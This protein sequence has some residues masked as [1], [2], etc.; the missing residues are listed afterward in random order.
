M[1]R[2]EKPKWRNGH[3]EPSFRRLWQV[4]VFFLSLIVMA[5]V[6][7]GR[8]LWRKTEAE[9]FR[10]RLREVQ[11]ALEARPPDLEEVLSLGNA[12][13]AESEQFPSLA[14]QLHFCLGSAYLLSAQDQEGIRRQASLKQARFHL[15]RADILGVPPRWKPKLDYRLGKVWYHFGHDPKQVIE[16]LRNTIETAA[17][18]QAEGYA[19]LTQ[20]Y[21]RLPVPD[22]ANALA[23]TKKHL[24]LPTA[25]DALL[26]PVRLLRGKLLFQLD[27]VDEARQVLGRIGDEAA[28]EIRAEARYWQ[29]KCAQR[30]LK[31]A[32]AAKLWEAVLAD[33][34]HSPK[35]RGR[36][37]CF[38]GI[39]Y[40]E[41][42]QDEDAI[43]VWE[44]A[45]AYEGEVGQAAAFALAEIK[46]IGPEPAAA[47]SYYERALKDVASADNYRNA[48]VGLKEARLLVERGCR[49]YRETGDYDRAQRLARL[50]QRIADRGV[51]EELYALA[52]DAW[53]LERKKAGDEPAARV[54][55]R[56]AGLAFASVADAVDKPDQQAKWLWLA[57][58]RLIQ[59][60][61]HKKALAILDRYLKVESDSVKLGQG[62]YTLAQVYE[63][64]KDES[65]ALVAYRKSIEYPGPYAFRAR[66]RLAIHD[67][68]MGNLDDAEAALQQNLELMREH[69]DPTTQEKCLYKLADLLFQRKR[70]RQASLRWREALD[71]FPDNPQALQAR[72]NLA[73]C[74]RQLA[75]EEAKQRANPSVPPD[76]MAHHQAQYRRW[77][78]MALANYKK[79]T[80]DLAAKQSSGTLTPD[81]D[82][83]LRQ[84]DFAIAECHIDLGQYQEAIQLYEALVARYHHQ[85][86]HL[87]ALRQIW[88]CHWIM[89]QP[90]KAKKTAEQVGR[91]LAEIDDEAFRK[92]P[93]SHTRQEWQQWLEWALSQ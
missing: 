45:L 28:P 10:E 77:L 14:G 61:D 33:S 91:V 20:A 66:Y 60:H 41:L 74:Y 23:T 57:A 86:E 90:A 85:V 6:W 80:L 50:Y 67:L 4:P 72:L 37:L 36:I 13:L 89:K 2:V 35:D 56:E 1:T 81:E 59:A 3:D 58:D 27:R 34:K 70:Y 83:I 62:W 42:Q 63:A 54:H 8:P 52:A 78:N 68:R 84:A 38:L 46:L 26:A 43:R 71:R 24:S 40:R 30:Q 22:V 47:F 25:N 29:A 49:R 18:D 93:D 21:L 79:I 92:R 82:R 44:A 39:C 16:R 87:Q 88:R 73:D 31:W 12:L 9:L 11:M 51:A 5:S 53:A 55:F 48:L 17:D 76:V 64:L 15:E 69:P 75:I 32:E 19:M 7:L 65:S